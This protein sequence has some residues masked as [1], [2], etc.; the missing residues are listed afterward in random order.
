M[1]EDAFFTNDQDVHREPV[2]ASK[3]NARRF[4]DAKRK[5]MSLEAVSQG[6]ASARVLLE[7]YL[8]AELDRRNAGRISP[9]V[10]ALYAAQPFEISVIELLPALNLLGIWVVFPEVSS[11]SR[12]LQFRRVKNSSELDPGPFGIRSPSTN[13]RLVALTDIDVFVVPALALGVNGDRLGRGGGYYDATLSA[14]HPERI[15]IGIAWHLC[16]SGV[17][18]VEAHD[19]KM[20]MVC[21]ANQLHK[22]A[23]NLGRT[24]E[25]LEL[26]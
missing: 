1:A 16:S 7:G 23:M 22:I 18:P 20:H 8:L 14:A 5:S 2:F 17:F 24:Q 25:T 4:F 10:V 21:S 26:A 13:C 9:A 3:S 6:S 15:S 11:D 12:V 19:V